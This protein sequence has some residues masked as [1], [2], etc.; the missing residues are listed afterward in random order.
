MLRVP[1]P[2]LR[3]RPKQSMVVACRDDY[4]RA[5][6]V[7]ATAALLKENPGK[8]RAVPVRVL[9]APDELGSVASEWM[10]KMALMTV[11]TSRMV[12]M[13]T[14][15]W[16]SAP[17]P[18]FTPV[19]LWL[20]LLAVPSGEFDLYPCDRPTLLRHVMDTTVGRCLYRVGMFL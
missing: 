7:R 1:R 3:P 4:V 5:N 18:A 6:L 9:L 13:M 8:V 17:A 12:V 20:S 16:A 10:R 2:M 15:V 19:V 14:T 11:V